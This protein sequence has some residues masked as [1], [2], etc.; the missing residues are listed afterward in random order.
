MD[1]PL[2]NIIRVENTDSRMV[3]SQGNPRDFEFSCSTLASSEQ[4]HLDDL[5]ESEG[6]FKYAYL[7]CLLDKRPLWDEWV[8]LG[9]SNKVLNDIREILLFNHYL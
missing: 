1:S 4:Q 3:S 9:F 6:M 7:P 5:L 8:R 2:A